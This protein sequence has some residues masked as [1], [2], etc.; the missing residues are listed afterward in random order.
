MLSGPVR[1]VWQ[2]KKKI[3]ESYQSG[4][5]AF[6][7]RRNNKRLLQGIVVSVIPLK[8]ANEVECVRGIKGSVLEIHELF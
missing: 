7:F 6:A 3:M 2:T 4:L 8:K 1:K 5:R